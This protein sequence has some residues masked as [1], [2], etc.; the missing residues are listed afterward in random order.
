ML[1][2]L[3]MCSLHLCV[4]LWLVKYTEVHFVVCDFQL[5]FFLVG[6]FQQAIST[7]L[8]MSL[9]TPVDQ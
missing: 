1:V 5:P 6:G 7:F 2:C 8:K 9:F 4:Q 3:I